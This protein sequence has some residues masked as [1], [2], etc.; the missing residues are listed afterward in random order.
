[1]IAYFPFRGSRTAGLRALVNLVL[2]RLA[3]LLK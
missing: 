3:T 1:M 2:S